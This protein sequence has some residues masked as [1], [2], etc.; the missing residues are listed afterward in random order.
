MFGNHTTTSETEK[1]KIAIAYTDS[2]AARVLMGRLAWAVIFAGSVSQSF[3]TF[4][5][6][7][8]MRPAT[9]AAWGVGALMLLLVKWRKT[10]AAAAVL[11]WGMGV[12]LS[13]S[14]LSSAGLNNVTWTAM[15]ML[16]IA[17]VWLLGKRHGMLVAGS[18]A[19]FLSYVLWMHKT[20]HVFPIL[21]SPSTIFV[22]TLVYMSVGLA[23]GISTQSAYEETLETSNDLAKGLK[24]A[25]DQL[26]ARVE[27]RTEAL[28]AVALQLSARTD[29]LERKIKEN[30]VMQAQVARAEK[31]DALTTM[32][33][34]IAH[35]LNTPIG[36]T[37]VLSS[38]MRNK[39]EAMRGLM[40]GKSVRKSDMDAVCGDMV[41]MSKMIEAST[42]KAAELIES[43]K[44]VSVDQ[45][46]ER[47]MV[48]SVEKL[49]V[50]VARLQRASRKNKKVDIH[51]SVEDGIPEMDAFPGALGQTVINLLQN[52]F[53]HAF[54]VDGP[55]LIEMSASY[56]KSLDQVHVVVKDNGKGILERD[57]G[58]IFDPF[59]S[60][61]VGS[62]GSG[63][64]LSVSHQLVTV[65]LGGRIEVQS[66][67][68]EGSSFM[69]KIPRVAPK[70]AG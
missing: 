4:Y 28:K 2:K 68:G 54:A 7:N 56:D 22:V 57:L 10:Y 8:G 45:A 58:R 3:Q 18:S 21:N 9:L 6:H 15:P 69:L 62:G 31:V 67:R 27:E 13:L 14:V 16:A 70:T 17:S 53:I 40:S 34:G 50:D 39:A 48:F 11:S 33:A 64:G 38:T 25:N 29:E 41:E 63:L 42:S 36:N 51:V 5:D 49:L 55:G 1:K 59:Y 24:E 61:R 60:T 44:R 19:L 26:E 37:L 43:F 47:R 20:G 23:I 66:K 65:V 52:A 35:E 30:E 46:S 32:I 12:G